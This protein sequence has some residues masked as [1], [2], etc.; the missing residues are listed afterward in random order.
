MRS[1]R[2]ATVSMQNANTPRVESQK[3][4]VRKNLVKG[5]R[6]LVQQVESIE[7]KTKNNF[8]YP[9]YDQSCISEIPNMILNLFDAK[10]EKTKLRTENMTCPEGI[11]KLCF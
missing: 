1:K 11:T 4:A 3:V 9:Q 2:S 5:D 10:K 8:V 7:K 6:M